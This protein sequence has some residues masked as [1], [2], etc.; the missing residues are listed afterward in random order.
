M[1]RARTPEELSGAEDTGSSSNTEVAATVA[2]LLIDGGGAASVGAVANAL[3]LAVPAFALAS[4]AIAVEV[5]R[6]AAELVLTD[7][8]K[9]DAGGGTFKRRAG[10]ENVVMRGFYGVAAT[11]RLSKALRGPADTSTRQRLAAALRAERSYLTAHNNA[12]RR[13]LAG[14]EATDRARQ[15]YGHD[16]TWNHGA[17]GQPAEPRPLHVAADG[18]AW[19]LRRGVPRSTGALPGVLPG[20][21]C[22]WGPPRPG[23]QT[24]T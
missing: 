9:I 7:P 4:P 6:Q 21:T 23:A 2:A 16:V 5:S 1:G 22:A 12:R 3:L 20:C 17:L 24:L 13:N 14:A 15:L 11:R 8:P 19:D 10:L 18:K